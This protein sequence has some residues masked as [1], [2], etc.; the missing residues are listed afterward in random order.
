M[1]KASFSRG[2]LE[3]PTADEPT[4]EKKQTQQ[5]TAPRR[6][7]SRTKIVHFKRP[8]VRFFPQAL[9]GIAEA[10]EVNDLPSARPP[11]LGEQGGCNDFP[12]AVRV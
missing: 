2:D 10:P 3:E 4:A 12:F 11:H 9:Q 8:Q 6:E 1:K 7:T 5:P